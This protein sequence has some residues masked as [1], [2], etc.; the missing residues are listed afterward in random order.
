VTRPP[1]QYLEVIFDRLPRSIEPAL[2]SWLFR[3]G[4]WGTQEKLDFVQE[5]LK[6]AP[7]IKQN[8]IINVSAYFD[9]EKR[10]EVEGPILVWLGEHSPQ[11][12]IQWQVQN[13]K[14]WLTEWKK[15]FKIFKVAGVK[16]VPAWEVKKLKASEKKTSLVI[17]PGMAFGTGTH[18]T[19]KFAME[20]IQKLSKESAV[21][22]ATVLD[23]GAGSGILSVVSEIYGAKSILAMDNDPESWRECKKLFKLNKTKRCKVT[24]KQITEIPGQYDLVIANIIDG[25]LIELKESLWKKTKSGGHII[26]SGILTV[27]ASAFEKSFL[28]DHKGSVIARLNDEE[29][30]SLLI[31]K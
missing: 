26:L 8:R 21:K 23:V 31:S 12:K 18:V 28:E 29:W 24:P 2:S 20:M 6:Y 4:C 3:H 30:T 5:D 11:T 1:T 9:P 16:V 27:G 22:S 15:H 17:E 19:T 14:D 10:E 25:V 7:L 13:S